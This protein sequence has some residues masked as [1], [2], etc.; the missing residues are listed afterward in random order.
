MLMQVALTQFAE[1]R[2]QG[3]IEV[4]SL[5]KVVVTNRLHVAIMANLL[6]R[7]LIWIDTQQ[8]KLS[9]KLQTWSS[10]KSPALL[11]NI[12]HGVKQM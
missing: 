2:L 4:V 7:P 6:G 10:W 12:L 9:S 8:K 1:S 5:G 11:L 3:A